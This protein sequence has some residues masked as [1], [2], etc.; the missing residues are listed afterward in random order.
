MPRESKKSKAERIANVI[1]ILRDT[2]PDAK[3]GLDYTTPF[4]LLVATILSAQ[5][6]DERVNI[7]TKDLFLKYKSPEDYLSVPQE[8]LE[9]DIRPTGFFRNKAKNIQR[10]CQELLDVF[11]G[12][13]PQTLE[14]LVTLPGVGR[15]TAN[16]VL[17]NCYNIPGITVDTHVTRISN[18]LKLVTT[19]DAV[20]I[21]FALMELI[22][23]DLWNEFNHLIITHGRQTCIARRPQCSTC[24]IN[25]LCPSA[26]SPSTSGTP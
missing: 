9:Q 5:C 25:H 7:V 4:E 18:L 20:K 1:G 22:E 24:T 21:E 2:Y 26:L 13:V 14:E 12:V 23:K 6:T 16:C 17:S 11:N 15:K 3:V 8:E 10:C 19:K